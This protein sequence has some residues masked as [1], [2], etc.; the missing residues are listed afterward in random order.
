MPLIIFSLISGCLNILTAVA[1]I[2]SVMVNC[3]YMHSLCKKQWCLLD[4]NSNFY[5]VSPINPTESS[6]CIKAFVSRE[7]V[8][9]SIGGGTRGHRGMCPHNFISAHRNLVFQNIE[10]CLV[11]SLCPYNFE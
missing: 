8:N 11:S 3:Y 4:N 7:C 1:Q 5:P 2:Q 9:E 6:F 10:M